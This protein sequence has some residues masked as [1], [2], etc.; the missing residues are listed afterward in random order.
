M[1][2]SIGMDGAEAVTEALDPRW[3]GAA[4]QKEHWHFYRRLFDHYSIILAP[5]EFS[6]IVEAIRDGRATLIQQRGPRQAIY[7]VRI[8]SVGERIYVLAAGERLITAMPP[9]R[10]F[11]AIR[12]VLACRD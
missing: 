6:G 12:R 5:G 9:N 8:K 3:H 2:F 10:R 7:C 4:I 11:S 1:G